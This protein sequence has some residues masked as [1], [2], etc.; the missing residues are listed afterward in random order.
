MRTIFYDYQNAGSHV[1]IIDEKYPGVGNV[2]SISVNGPDTFTETRGD[3]PTRTFTYTHLVP[4][5]GDDC[6]GA[7]AAYGES[8][9]HNKM[10]TDY[11]DFNG[12]NTHIG[13]DPNTW[14]V[15]SVLDARG[16]TTAYARA[17]PPPTAIGQITKITYPDLAHVDYGYQD[18]CSTIGG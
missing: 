16:N 3:G 2:S 9:P 4:C 7:C 13:Y 5:I 11:T 14:Y 12:Q 8:E 1:A 15:T 6:D 18:E 17:S 10:L